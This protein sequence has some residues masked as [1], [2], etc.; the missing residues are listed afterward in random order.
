MTNSVLARLAIKISANI[1]EF[2]SALKDANNQLNSFKSSVKSTLAQIGA[3]FTLYEIG[4]QMINVTA[5]FERFESVLTNTLGSGSQAKK[6]L[7]DIALF[8]KSTP[9]QVAE[10]TNAYVR[11]ANLG[12]D[13]NI[14][15]MRMLGDVAASLGAG[16]E[17]TAEAFKDL[18]VGQTK[19]IEEIG[20]SAVQ[21]NG[22]IQLSFK[23]LNIEI[24][25]NAQGVMQALEAYSQ[26]NGVLGT[27]DEIAKSLTGKISNLKDSWDLFLKAV[28]EKG[29]PVLKFTI[30]QL[31]EFLDV[32]G[33]LPSKFKLDFGQ[34]S[35]ATKE[36]L[37]YLLKAGKAGLFFTQS[38]PEALKSITDLPL[39]D[40]FRK[41]GE[42]TD[43]VRTKLEQLGVTKLAAAVLSQRYA[44]NV[45]TQYNEELNAAEAAAESAQKAK[46]LAEETKRVN[47]QKEYQQWLNERAVARQQYQVYLAQL[48][49]LQN[50]KRAEQL[51]RLTK[52]LSEYLALTNPEVS[53]KNKIGEKLPAQL[54]REQID[55]LKNLQIGA[56]VATDAIAELNNEFKNAASDGIR[57]FILGLGEVAEGQITFGENILKAIAVFAKQFGEYVLKIA[58]TKL[59]LDQ[60]FTKGIFAGPAGALYAIGAAT[61]LLAIAGG[62]AAYFNN[63]AS[64]SNSGMT[65]ASNKLEVTGKLIGSGRDL[66]AVIDSTNFDN[67]YRKGG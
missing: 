5:E 43:L 63:K 22:K 18:M 47:D 61:A 62:S 14:K 28:G 29:S 33:N 35:S 25:K 24:E 41:L 48:E 34:I 58:I 27:Q 65:S 45:V 6:A 23:G 2:S 7:D 50:K 42:N 66:V 57:S 54:S 55:S 44:Q 46:E 64:K 60:L 51:E 56:T 11:W 4:R 10:I 19:R 17:Q 52:A 9:Y 26:L 37:D 13:P 30:D 8:A 16:F 53:V 12:L 67:K 31:T 20:I 38:I 21:Q 15:K 36:E 32:A 39:A 40:Q 3:G 1:A 49:I 59:G